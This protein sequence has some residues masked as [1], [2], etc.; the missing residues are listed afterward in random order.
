LKEKKDFFTS[1]E[2]YFKGQS[3]T[4]LLTCSIIITLLIG[5]GDY[6][7]GEELSLAIFYIFPISFISWFTNR[8]ATIF[9]CIISSVIEFVANY[10]AGRTYSHYLIFFWNSA[11]LLSFFLLYAFILSMLQKE[12]RS[13]IKLIDE[14]QDSLAELKHTREELEQKSQDLVRSNIDLQQFAYTASHDLQA[15]LRGVE[16][17]V[18]LFSR[19]YK[20][21]LDTKADEFIEFI[22][23]GVKRMQGLIK[24]LLEYSQIGAK[25]IH[26]KP[27]ESELA[28]TQALANL[29]T[30]IEESSAIVTYE[31]LP[32]IIGDSSQMSSLFQNLIGNAIKY[33]KE[34]PPKIH[35]S[36]ER[37]GDKWLFSV[38]D[39][40]IGIDLNNS[41]RIFVVFQRLHTREEYEGTGIGL[42]ICKRIVERHK[43]DIW[44]ESEIGKGSTF[45]FTIPDQ[46]SNL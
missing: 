18:N 37:K 44:I 9:I 23:D 19:R 2:E 25:E 38:N 15:P 46:E 13:R 20:G 42:A 12:Y 27:M 36:A 45:Y 41:A 35:I 14:L 7:T 31:T 26:W 39:N 34:E 24:D 16:G 40:G 30:A 3:T 10:A 5:V 1:A 22:I 29:K 32:R 6:I 8:N 17:F 11:L 4:F 28:V 21:K 33:R 43:G